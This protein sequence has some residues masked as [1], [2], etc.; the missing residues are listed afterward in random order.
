MVQLV[1]EKE[2][3]ERCGGGEDEKVKRCAYIRGAK[4]VRGLLVTNFFFKHTD[5]SISGQDILD[6]A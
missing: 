2:G 1:E 6:T 3:E 4:S 5:M